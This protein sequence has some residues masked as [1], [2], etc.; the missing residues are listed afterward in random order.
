MTRDPKL[1]FSDKWRWRC[2]SVI[3]GNLVWQDSL[4]HYNT[5][6]C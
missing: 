3:I 1:V 6:V 5:R 4:F 2:P